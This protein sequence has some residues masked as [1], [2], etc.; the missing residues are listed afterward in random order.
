MTFD[1]NVMRALVMLKG[2]WRSRFQEWLGGRAKVGVAKRHSG[3]RWGECGNRDKGTATGKICR[4]D[5]IWILVT[6]FGRGSGT[7]GVGAR[8]IELIWKRKYIMMYS[9]KDI[10]R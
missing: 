9:V 10:S 3:N 4:L 5:K 6:K 8:E 1:Y 2:M 7:F